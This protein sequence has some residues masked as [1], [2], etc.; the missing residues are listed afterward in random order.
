MEMK[1]S[2]VQ[3]KDKAMFNVQNLLSAGNL[4]RWIGKIKRNSSG[5]VFTLAKKH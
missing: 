3:P 5:Q 4:T 1:L 2:R